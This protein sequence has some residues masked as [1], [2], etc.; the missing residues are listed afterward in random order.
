MRG[1]LA[2]ERVARAW[3]LVNGRDFVVADDVELLFEPVVVHRLVL[4]AGGA[5]D[6]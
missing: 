1:S 5:L 4:A 2:L 6:G 3:A